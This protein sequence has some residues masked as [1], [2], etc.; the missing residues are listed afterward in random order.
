MIAGSDMHGNAGRGNVGPGDGAPDF[1]MARKVMV[2]SQLRPSGVNDRHVIA[3]MATVP[4]ERFVPASRVGS[5]YSDRPVPLGG[6]RELNP[7]VITGRLLTELHLQPSDRVLLVGAATGYAAALLT[8]IVVGPVAVEEDEAL[9]SVA[10]AQLGDTDVEIVQGPLANGHAAGAP[11]DAILIDGAVDRI[12]DALVE[13]LAPGG[14]LATGLIDAGI[15]RLVVGRRGGSGF[16]VNAF[17]DADPVRLPGF[18]GPRA[19]VF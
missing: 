11:Y 9:I 19:F 1:D 3:A 10:R 16:G 7:P 14:R 15:G 6:A 12:P 18:A 2:A 13:Q 5:A 17:E 8:R 4:R